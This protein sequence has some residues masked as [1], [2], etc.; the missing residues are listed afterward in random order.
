MIYF[1]CN[2]I[3]ETRLKQY[4]T[5]SDADGNNLSRRSRKEEKKKEGSNQSAKFA[6]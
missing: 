1:Y 3:V 2:V 5:P 4:N 6:T